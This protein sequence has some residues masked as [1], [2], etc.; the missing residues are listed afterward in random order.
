[1]FLP[2]IVLRLIEFSNSVIYNTLEL[3]K[4]LVLYG[5]KYVSFQML[6]YRWKKNNEQKNPHKHISYTRKKAKTKCL[7]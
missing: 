7:D 5:G 3:G 6:C 1:M 4:E 2:P